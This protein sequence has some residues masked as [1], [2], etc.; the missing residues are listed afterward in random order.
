MGMAIISRVFQ[1]DIT[2]VEP[3]VFTNCGSSTI[4]V[5]KYDSLGM[6]APTVTDNS[7]AVDTIEPSMPLATPIDNDVNITWTATDHAGNTETCVFVVKIR[8]ECR[9]VIYF[10][11]LILAY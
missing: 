1:Y 9:C 3:P 5:K 6:S 2:D 10:V 8:S 7:G 4:F 11:I